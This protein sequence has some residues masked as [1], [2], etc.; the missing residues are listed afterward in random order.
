M[1]QSEKIA[2]EAT[3]AGY[4][5]AEIIF[6]RSSSRASRNE[7]IFARLASSVPDSSPARTSAATTAPKH[8]GCSAKAAASGEPATT[9][10]YMSDMTASKRRLLFCSERIFSDAAAGTPASVIVA[11]SRKNSAF[12]ASFTRRAKSAENEIFAAPR[13]SP[14]GVISIG[15][16]PFSRSSDAAARSSAASI[17]PRA[18]SPP[19]VFAS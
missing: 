15:V 6:L 3:S 7:A 11:S 12:S 8:S 16:S 5:S 14:A 4:V 18:F 19:H 10:A 2:T 17:S 1:T 9:R 13:F